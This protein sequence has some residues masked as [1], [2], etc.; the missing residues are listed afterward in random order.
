MGVGGVGSAC[1]LSWRKRR[2]LLDEVPWYLYV[3][4]LGGV[5]AFPTKEDL[6]ARGTFIDVSI[7]EPKPPLVPLKP[8]VAFIGLREPVLVFSYAEYLHRI[9]GALEAEFVHKVF[10]DSR[11][12]GV[13][14][15][16][17]PDVTVT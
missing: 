2:P 5:M 17:I 13:W 7:L 16:P 10:C 3:L 4:G 6:I 11:G 8:V 12:Y 1:R 15:V 9:P 14:F